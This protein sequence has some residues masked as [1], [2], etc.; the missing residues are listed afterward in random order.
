M[1]DYGFAIT[2]IARELDVTFFNRKNMLR[3]VSLPEQKLTGAQFSCRYA[4]R[5]ELI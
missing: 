2:Q 4:P 5:N 3:T 1:H